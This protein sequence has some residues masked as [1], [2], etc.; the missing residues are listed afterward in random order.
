MK[1]SINVVLVLILCVFSVCSCDF[2]RKVAGR[3]DSAVIEQKRVEIAAAQ[4]ALKDSIA[5]ADSLRQ[6]ELAVE[7]AKKLENSKFGIVLGSFKEA[8]NAE[9]LLQRAKDAG[10][11]GRIF[12]YRGLQTV[13]ICPSDD[14]EEV[15]KGLEV[16]SKEPFCPSGAW[17][18]EAK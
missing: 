10:Y 1:R 6:V 3:P 17:I 13:L 12:N 9:K 8:Q 15:K 16:V 4:K 14:A 5:R 7:A 18:Y 2:L 11:A